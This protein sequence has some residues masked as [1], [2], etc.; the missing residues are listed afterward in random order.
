MDFKRFRLLYKLISKN[1]KLSEKRHPMFERNRFMKIFT[2]GMIAFMACYFIFFGVVLGNAFLNESIEACDMLNQGIL[3]LLIFDFWL[4]FGMQETPGQEV[5]PYKVMPIPTNS[6]IHIFLIK[7]GWNWYNAFFLFF[8]IPFGFLTV[9]QMPYFGWMSFIGYMIGVW[10]LFVLNAYWYL[11]WRTLINQHIIYILLPIIFYAAIIFAGMVATDWLFTASMQF[12]R[13]FI[14][15]N[16]LCF[17]IVLLCIVML[18]YVN[19]WM[20]KKFLYEEIAKVEKVKKVKSQEMSFLNRYGVVGEYLKL[21]IKSIARNNVVRKI[22]LS[23]LI[24]TLIFCAITA[25]TPAYDGGFMRIFI[26]VYCFAVYGIMTLTNVMGVEGNYIDG[27][28]SRKESV[29]SLLKAKYYFYIAMLL[30]PTLSMIAPVATG[31]Y[32]IYEMLGCLFFTPGCIFPCLFILAIFNNTTM[33]LTQKIQQRT[34]NSKAQFFVSMAA[35]FVPMIIMYV[36]VML[37]GSM[38]G[39]IVMM[40]L[41]LI[42][43]VLH[44]VWLKAIYKQFMIRR[45]E[46]MSS[47]RATRNA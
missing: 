13:G 37:M 17:L 20:Q 19:L 25:F 7:R 22:F 16:P 35:M 24:I 10:L 12:M 41:G 45:Y 11:I 15:W 39:G 46:N 44:H 47:F 1:K 27:L 28:M 8:F 23:G 31:K 21:E 36:L 4:R 18:Y 34:T 26:C 40:G 33:N 29:L 2:Y 30:I 3:F 5:K 43:V 14:E 42:G 32:T 9:A 38:W 6:I